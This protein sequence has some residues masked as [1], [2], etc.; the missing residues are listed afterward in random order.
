MLFNRGETYLP[1]LMGVK[2]RLRHRLKVKSIIG[3]LK[4]IEY[5][6]Q[7]NLHNY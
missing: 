1:K 2:A 5:P 6:D 3:P 7:Q 4:S